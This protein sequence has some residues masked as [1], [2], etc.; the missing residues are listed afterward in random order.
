MML[1]AALHLSTA[2]SWYARWLLQ[3]CIRQSPAGRGEGR[4]GH[5]ASAPVQ[6][7]RTSC[8]A[9]REAG[10]VPLARQ[11]WGLCKTSTVM[12]PT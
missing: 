12:F 1:R 10:D 2:S 3:L 5:T 4:G 6:W 8:L 9:A 11:P 7:P